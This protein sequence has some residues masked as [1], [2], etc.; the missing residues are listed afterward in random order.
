V[1]GLVA[2]DAGA[3]S[4]FLARP[5]GAN[6]IEWE[7]QSVRASE[8]AARLLWPLGDLS[9]RKRLHR[10][11]VPTLVLWGSADRVVPASYAKLYAD[12]ISGPVTVRSI[13]GAGHLLDLD[14]PIE[15][16]EIVRTF[17]R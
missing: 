9:V 5:E 16:A 1:P 6:P 4:A 15:A 10:I 12:E 11:R 2:T 8:A 3:I 17:L 7:I 13:D 14:A